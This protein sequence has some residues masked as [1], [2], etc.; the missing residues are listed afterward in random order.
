MVHNIKDMVADYGP[1]CGVYIGSKRLVVI[2]DLDML[3]GEIRG[4]YQDCKKGKILGPK[5]L[6][7]F[8]R[9]KFFRL[10]I[11][12]IFHFHGVF[13]VFSVLTLLPGKVFLIEHLFFDLVT[14]FVIL[15]GTIKIKTKI[16]VH[17]KGG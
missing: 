13:F 1:I 5:I 9:Y 17:L 15:Q 3:K 7:I 4:V 10:Q 12:R 11:P 8:F 14:F 6:G 2:A 16:V